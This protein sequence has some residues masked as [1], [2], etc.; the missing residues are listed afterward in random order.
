MTEFESVV[1]EYG[2]LHEPICELN[3]EYGADDGCTCAMTAIVAAHQLAID[4]AVAETLNN[5]AVEVHKWRSVLPVSEA[6]LAENAA[7][8]RL[9]QHID[10][11]LESPNNLKGGK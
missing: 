3:S 11:R 1:E 4:K 9:T 2:Q 5:V 7:Y 8:S 10:Y 6:Q